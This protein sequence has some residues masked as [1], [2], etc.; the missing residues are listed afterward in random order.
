MI[1]LK[2]TVD[3]KKTVILAVL[4]IVVIML[5]GVNRFFLDNIVMSAIV[6]TLSVF[7]FVAFVWVY[8][9]SR[10]ATLKAQRE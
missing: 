8:V 1:T 4:G 5:A 9:S 10:R 3:Q 2:T 6:V 7:F